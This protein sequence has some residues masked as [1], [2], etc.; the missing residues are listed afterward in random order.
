MILK[1]SYD[2]LGKENAELLHEDKTF[3]VKILKT[4]WEM[5]IMISPGCL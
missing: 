4:F 3:I 5:A 1:I 2:I